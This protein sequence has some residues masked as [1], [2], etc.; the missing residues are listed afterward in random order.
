MYINKKKV[1]KKKVIEIEREKSYFVCLF[2][3]LNNV[4]LIIL[5]LCVFLA[6]EEIDAI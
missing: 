2:Y 3:L 5:F 1:E 4:A 6:N